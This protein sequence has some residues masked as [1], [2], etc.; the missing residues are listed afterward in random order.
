MTIEQVKQ[1]LAALLLTLNTT[2]QETVAK[3]EELLATLEPAITSVRVSTAPQLQAVLDACEVKNIEL[4]PGRYVGPVDL[5]NCPTDDVTTITGSVDAVIA[6]PDTRPALRTDAGA[7]HY[8]LVGFSIAPNTAPGSYSAVQLG[9]GEETTLAA[10]PHT[11]VV[12]G[13]TYRATTEA[14]VRA[15]A[16]HVRN[17]IF[18]NVKVYGLKGKGMDTQALYVNGPC[19][20]C[21]FENNYLEGAGENVMFGGADPRIAGLVPRN[22]IFRG[23][24]LFKPLEWKAQGWTVKNIFEL[25]NASGILIENNLFENHWVQAQSGY[26]IVFTPRNQGGKAPWST[27]EDVTFRGNIVR[28]SPAAINILGTDNVYPS[29]RM[30]NV[31]IERNLFTA[32]GKG[33][34]FQIG[35]GPVGVVIDHNTII[36]VPGSN[37]VVMVYGEPAVGFQFTNNVARHEL[38]GIISAD[39][40]GYG[41]PAIAFHFPGAI[42]DR[43]VLAGGTARMYPAGNLFPLVTDFEAHFADYAAGILKPGTDWT[44]LGTDGKDLGR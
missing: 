38:Y 16:F 5:R 31:R 28:N 12:D 29:Q 3:I 25:K 27:V 33:N 32:V 41:N 42:I 1:F 36:S 34:I 10:V 7:H 2:H 13:L 23:N 37:S 20:P 19:D 4:A 6:S 22:I 17:G 39:G 14:Q 8:T 43:N 21:L 44:N 40:K 15:F 24:H 35:A 30:K 9:T 26:A 11:F 18:R